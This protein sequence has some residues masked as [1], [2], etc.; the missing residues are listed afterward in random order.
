M[1]LLAAAKYGNSP[2]IMDAFTLPCL[3]IL[4][5]VIRS[6]S[7]PPAAPRKKDKDKSGSPESDQ[8][9]NSQIR[10]AVDVRAW[11]R[12]EFSFLQWKHEFDVANVY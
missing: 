1:L 4:Q 12:E 7:P 6:G 9:E 8:L 5:D 10:P 2:A 11:L 3:N